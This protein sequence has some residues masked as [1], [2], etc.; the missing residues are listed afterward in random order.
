VTTTRLKTPRR[1]AR[2]LDQIPPVLIVP[3]VL[4]IVGGGIASVSRLRSAYEVLAVPTP[5]LPIVII[6]SPLPLQPPTAVPAVQVAAV[7]PNTLRR[8]AVAYDAPGGMS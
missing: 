2:W 7:L 3:I 5:M 6:A 4:F 1:A 8:A